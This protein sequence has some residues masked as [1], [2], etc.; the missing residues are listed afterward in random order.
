LN[1]IFSFV[2]GSPTLTALSGKFN[3]LK[4][5]EVE[6]GTESSVIDEVVGHQSSFGTIKMLALGAAAIAKIETVKINILV[7]KS[8]V[9]P[10]VFAMD[11]APVEDWGPA[12]YEPAA[13]LI[14]KGVVR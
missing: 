2:I 9:C 1:Q 3:Y 10:S 11:H 5:C 6:D 4:K 7:V 12:R 8:P 14:V 13:A